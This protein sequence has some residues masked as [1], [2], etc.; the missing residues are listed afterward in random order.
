MNNFS[1]FNSQV[2]RFLK[3]NNVRNIKENFYIIDLW[4]E[5]V[6][7][8]V[9]N[10]S[11]P[12]RF[13]GG[14]IYAEIDSSAWANE[15]TYIKEDIIS[16]YNKKLKKHVVKDIRFSLK[17]SEPYSKPTIKIDKTKDGKKGSVIKNLSAED[18]EK[19]EEN[20]E[21][22]EDEQLKNSMKKFLEIT[23]KRELNLLQQGW[24]KCKM[25]SCL[26]KDKGDLCKP[27]SFKEGLGI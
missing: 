7:D 24:K 3:D 19:I 27:C 18:K 26:H 14:V 20:T 1:D 10:N 23:R 16:K 21:H 4:N 13:S 8:F 9:A 17:K 22:I 5:L 2:A 6:G 25:C 15:M 11:K 12:I